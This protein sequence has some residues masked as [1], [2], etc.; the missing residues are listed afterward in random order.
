MFEAYFDETGSHDGAAVLSVA[1]FIFE[2]HKASEMRT[3]WQKVLD[4]NKMPYLH[5]SEFAAGGGPYR[6]LGKDKRIEIQ[7]E[8]HAILH[9][10]AMCGIVISVSKEAFNRSGLSDS[11]LPNP[12]ALCCYLCLLAV[13][14]T[15]GERKLEA[16]LTYFFEEGHRNQP[17]TNQ[18]MVF[19]FR[20]LERVTHSFIPKS[21]GGPIQA[22]DMLAWLHNKYV[23][24]LLR[25]EDRMRQDLRAL[26]SRV[27]CDAAC[28]TTVGDIDAIFER[29]RKSISETP[30]VRVSGIFAG[31]PFG[32]TVSNSCA[33]RS[34]W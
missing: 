4:E 3:R 34:Y 21:D 22:A 24:N 29:M 10:A 12:Y 14:E 7:R 15:L 23:A 18:M 20:N 25:G 6:H 30:S 19:L 11:A 1:G 13:V 5:M 31:M 32:R 27:R 17:T 2:S 28:L 16:N 9:D 33:E 26:V 8:L